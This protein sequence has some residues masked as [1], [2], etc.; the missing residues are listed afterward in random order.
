MSTDNAT[1]KADGAESLSTAGLGAW[2]PIGTAPKDGSLVLLYFPAGF[3]RSTLS[4]NIF[5]GHWHT[6]NN[7]NYPGM[8]SCGANRNL[9]TATHWMPLPKTP[10]V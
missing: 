3:G 5:I 6:P 1:P 7:K 2:F 9:K 10:N 8:W 4:Q